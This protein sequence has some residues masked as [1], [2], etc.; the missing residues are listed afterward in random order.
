M[1]VVGSVTVL[2]K[3]YTGDL[4]ALDVKITG[5]RVA[6]YN[7]LI[8]YKTVGHVTCRVK[9]L[10]V[11]GESK[12]DVRCPEGSEILIFIDKFDEE[13]IESGDRIRVEEAQSTV[14]QFRVAKSP[15]Q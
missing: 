2:K 14:G 12:V 9:D 15:A 6:L 11:N 4:I 10:K 5:G 3:E 8:I 1:S 7:D 13:K